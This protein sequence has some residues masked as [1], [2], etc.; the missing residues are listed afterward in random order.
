MADR[1]SH[2][3]YVDLPGKLFH[4]LLAS[5]ND[6]HPP[7]ADHQFIKAFCANAFSVEVFQH[8]NVNN[9][10]FRNLSLERPV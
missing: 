2:G 10:C 7:A 4:L 9:F 6:T 5:I 1:S 3:K 8:F